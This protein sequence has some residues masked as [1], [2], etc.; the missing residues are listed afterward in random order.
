MIKYIRID[1]ETYFN[2]FIDLPKK[3][4]ITW[5]V[6]A[7]VRDVSIYTF[8]SFVCTF[9]ILN[10]YVIDNVVMIGQLTHIICYELSASNH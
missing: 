10:V 7:F 1:F 3:I 2:D 6:F 4:N 9:N 8:N 5:I